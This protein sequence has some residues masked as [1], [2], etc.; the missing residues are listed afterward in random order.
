MKRF[1]SR[2]DADA[3]FEAARSAL[4]EGRLDDAEAK[5]QD[6]VRSGEVG[7]ATWFN[8]GLIHKFR[9][10]W[11][12][13]R[14]ANLRCLD[15]EPGNH[16]ATWNL[17][18][19]ATALRDWSTARNAWRDLNIDVG[20]GDGA[21]ET[22]LGPAPV[23]LNAD[24]DGGGEVVWGT[25][26]DPCR[27]RIDSVP[28]PESGHRWGDIVLHDV[29][30]RGQRLFNGRALSVFDELE[31]MEPC[32]AATH[33]GEVAWASQDDEDALHTELA[34][35]NLGGEDWSTSIQMIC[36]ACSLSDAQGHEHDG[37]AAPQVAVHRWAFAGDTLEIT[38]ALR[39]WASNGGGRR[40]VLTPPEV[41]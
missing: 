23:R 2:F 15:L 5:F 25:R 39:S 8:L 19:V 13:A 24:S 7:P 34:A 33:V 9:H 14:D 6:I 10:D 1:L 30:P 16:E 31:R 26:I 41:A 29:V 18:V 35:R 21:P 12:A 40:V 38:E 27:V 17:G 3:V 36:S 4:D 28:L 20:T 32:E 11:A 22:D 37:V